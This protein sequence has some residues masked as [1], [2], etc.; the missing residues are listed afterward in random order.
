MGAGAGKGEMTLCLVRHGE[1]EWNLERRVQGQLDPALTPLGLAQAEM[2]AARLAQEEWTTLYSSDLRRAFK[3]AEAVSLTTGL[4]LVVR[5]NLREQGQGL[6]EGLLMRDAHTLFPSLAAPE[7]GRESPEALRARA[8]VA[9]HAIRDA[10]P[11]ERVVVVSHGALMRA[12][13]LAALPGLEWPGLTN[14]ACSLLHWDGTC[15]SADY[16]NDASHLAALRE[17]AAFSE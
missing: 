8:L 7:L 9:F 10:H 6:R 5:R 13:L 17:T 12:F 11:G 2:V 3:T 16:V 14:T 15:W 4:P 1:S